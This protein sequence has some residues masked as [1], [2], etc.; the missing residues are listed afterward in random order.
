MNNSRNGT[1]SVFSRVLLVDPQ[2]LAA[3]VL[4]ADQAAEA[5]GRILLLQ[6]RVQFPQLRAVRRQLTARVELRFV[7]AREPVDDMVDSFQKALDRL[8]TACQRFA[9][10]FS[11]AWRR[12]ARIKPWASP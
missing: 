1:R 2:K 3:F 9:F 8:S 5:A 7:V 6:N 12:P 11:I 10:T 4:D